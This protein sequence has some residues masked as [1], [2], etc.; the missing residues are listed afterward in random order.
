[1][2]IAYPERHND[3]KKMD[4]LYCLAICLFYTHLW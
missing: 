3:V 1:M 4:R 2:M